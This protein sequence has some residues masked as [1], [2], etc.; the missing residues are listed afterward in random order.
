MHVRLWLV[1]LLSGLLLCVVGSTLVGGTAQFA[2]A[3]LAVLIA[4]IAVSVW[5]GGPDNYVEPSNRDERPPP[6][7]R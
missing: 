1:F 5:A 3:C 4:L 6:G 2:L 7:W